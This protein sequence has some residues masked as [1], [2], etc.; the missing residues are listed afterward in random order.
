MSKDSR[1]VI[2]VITP[3]LNQGAF[4]EQTIRSVLDQ[5]YPNLEYIVMDGGSTDE[6]VSILKKYEGKLKW[7]SK[8]DKGQSDAINQG[9]RMA[10]GDIVAWLGSDDFYMPGTLHRVAYYFEKHHTSVWLTGDYI[11]VDEMGRKIQS[12]VR[13]YK[14]MLRMSN[15]FNTLSFANYV[16]QPSTFWRRSLHDEFG[17]VDERLHYCM[18]Y[19]FWL[20]IMKKY[21]LSFI[22]LPLSGFRIHKDSKSGS[23]YNLQF[24]EE[25]EVAKRYQK[26]M[27]I[28]AL[29]KLHNHIIRAIYTLIK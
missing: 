11:I 26:N 22:P 27:A 15:S 20:R 24:E 9:L 25:V 3:S 10:K 2:S 17:Y 14:N 28:I 5:G 18:D 29:H 19:D 21:P 6:T 1:P 8:K 13:V 12:P 4:L 23:Q 16:N 7:I